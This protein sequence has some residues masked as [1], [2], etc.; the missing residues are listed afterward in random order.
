V[1]D[2]EGASAADGARIIQWEPNGGANQRWRFEPVGQNRFRIV[3]VA[4]GKVLD[5]QSASPAN[6]AQLIQWP[7]N[8]GPNQ[9]WTL[10]LVGSG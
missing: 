1:L 4:T 6:G 5:V 8:G 3:S 10:N 2:V 9:Q 7:W